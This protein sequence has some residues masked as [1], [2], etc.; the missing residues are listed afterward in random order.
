MENITE[1]QVQTTENTKFCK[2]C[3]EKIPTDA[4]FCTK[5]G[6][7]VEGVSK[8]AIEQP[9]IIINNTNANPNVNAGMYGMRA[10]SKWV[11]FLL[12][13]F[14][15]YVGAHK[16]YE[17]KAGMGILYLLTLGLCGIGWFIN[18]ISLLLKPN[19][20]YVKM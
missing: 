20:Y 16:F 12:C 19:P 4:V 8:P 6:Y 11:A 18:C 13:L 1:N 9:Q 14:L 5:C 10:R 15:G 7:Q 2:R 17:G 3:G